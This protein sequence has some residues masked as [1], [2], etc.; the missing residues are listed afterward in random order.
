MLLVATFVFQFVVFQQLFPPLSCCWTP[1]NSALKYSQDKLCVF[2]ASSLLKHQKQSWVLKFSRSH[3]RRW[4][5]SPRSSGVVCCWCRWNVKYSLGYVLYT[6]D[7][8]FISHDRE[9][10]NKMPGKFHVFPF[11]RR[12]DIFFWQREQKCKYHQFCHSTSSKI[13]VYKHIDILKSFAYFCAFSFLP[14]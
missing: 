2:V 8:T 6:V 5:I 13:G 7:S 12:S 10:P 9:W 3:T 14:C 1:R 4:D 11:S